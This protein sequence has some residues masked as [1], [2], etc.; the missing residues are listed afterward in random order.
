MSTLTT[1][2]RGPRRRP[3][4]IAAA[5]ALCTAAAGAQQPPAK[6]P[7]KPPVAQAW[8]DVATFSGMGAGLGGM[9]AGSGNNPLSALGGLF[10]VGGGG[11]VPFLSTQSGGSGGRY[12]DVTLATRANPQLAEGTQAV[13]AGLQVGPALKLLSPKDAKP[14]PGDDGDERVEEP[15]EKPKGRLLLYWGCGDAVRSGQPRVLDVAKLKP[16]DVAKFFI[17]R[18]ATQRGAHS[19]QGRPHWPNPSEGKRVPEGGS[20]VG[21]HEFKGQGV[22][23]G[24]K[25]AIPTANDLMPAL[26]LST[27]DKAGATALEWNALPTARGY[28]AGAFAGKGEQADGAS[29]MVI[30]TSSELPDTG[31]GLFDYQTNPAVE[32]WVKERVLLA[33]STTRCTV[34]KGVLPAEGSFLRLIA[35][36]PE[37]NL[38][39]PP[40]PADP[41]AVWE[42]QWAVKLRVKSMTT[43]M[44][45]MPSMGDV[46]KG[47]GGTAPASP[48]PAE[49][50]KK[51]GALDLLRGVLGR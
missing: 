31:F 30:W 47:E 28:F 3:V 37:L 2:L 51:P 25:F 43:A 19:A 26:T 16:E 13:P 27:A 14:V 23:E 34:P 29:E 1:L 46:M 41:K 50:K 17:S 21:E 49:D 11:S 9:G 20:L 38:A 44:P 6:G 15:S 24:F 22:P 36:G 18:R 33:P 8:I 4:P 42:P 45:G 10:G 7:S 32:R 12:M 39:H 35:Y 48:P 40:R 5:L